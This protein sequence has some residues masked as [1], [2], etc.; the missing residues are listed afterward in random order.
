MFFMPSNFE[1]PGV[2]LLV[3]VPASTALCAQTNTRGPS[4]D[5]K[6]MKLTRFIPTQLPKSSYQSL[7]LSLLVSSCGGEVPSRIVYR[8][9]I[10]IS[11]T[12]TAYDGP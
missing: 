11:W 1:A 2:S 6:H 7:I 5:M 12:G 9:Q 10:M 4:C 3:Q 8:M